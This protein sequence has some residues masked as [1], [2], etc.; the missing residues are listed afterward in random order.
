MK[1]IENYVI[2]VL[3]AGTLVAG[4]ALQKSGVYGWTLFII[5]PVL[6][7]ALAERI[8]PH[9]TL[10]G[11]V[12]MGALAGC[13]PLL[14]L[15]LLGIEGLICIAM[16]APLVVPLAI[17]GSVIINRA[18]PHTGIERESIAMLILLPIATMGWDLSAK[19]TVYEVHTQMEIAA[20]P[21]QVWK[22]IV[23]LPDFPPPAEWMF[24]EGIAHPVAT[25]TEGVGVG[26]KRYCVLST[27]DMLEEVEVWDEPH[28][29][30]FRVLETPAPMRE[31]SLYKQITPS[32]LRGYY[33]GKTGEF[34]LKRL[35]DNH[36]LVE[37]MSSY[38][39]GLWPAQYWRLWSDEVV[40]E[41]H[42]RVLNRIRDLAEHDAAMISR[43]QTGSDPGLAK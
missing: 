10:T 11:A 8:R 34:R 20:S 27:G 25:R 24:R 12:K 37:G 23:N 5:I 19:P 14:G 39:H 17:V 13:I 41:V 31:L 21:E 29:L 33:H 28:V 35:A 32:H 9:E 2:G 15:L 30:R 40:H 42:L 1:R 38:Q 6:V 36:T 7:G 22:Y 18:R 26:V 16:A 3:L 43:A 4:F